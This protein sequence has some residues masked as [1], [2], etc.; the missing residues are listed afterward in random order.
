MRA[1]LLS[2]T[3][4]VSACASLPEVDLPDL[5]DLP[6]P[7]VEG[8]VRDRPFMP[9]GDYPVPPNVERL[10]GP[11][12]CRG[13]TLAAVSADLPRYPARE[14]VR[15]RQGWVVVRFDVAQPG[16]VENIRI[17]RSVPGGGFNRVARQAVSDWQFQPLSGVDRL[18]N[19]VVMF[20]F[21]AGEV[22]IR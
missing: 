16:E 21:R 4:C 20:E 15:G 10:I 22:R 7:G 13:S 3:L 17:A 19:C 9:T 14:Y 5:P 2:L 1:L 6:V 11:E 8:D 18:Q 12:D